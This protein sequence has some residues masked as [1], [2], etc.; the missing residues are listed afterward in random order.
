MSKSLQLYQKYRPTTL[1]D[2]VGHSNRVTQIKTWMKE[3][4]PQS[5]YIYGETGTGKTT[6]ARIIAS[7]INCTG[8]GETTPC[9][10][11]ESCLS[12]IQETFHLDI[13][14]INASNMNVDAARELDAASSIP[15]FFGGKK[16]WIIN[17]FQELWESPKAR[18]NLLEL[19]ENKNDNV[20]VI[21]TSMDDSKVDKAIRDRCKKI[22]LQGL[23]DEDILSKLIEVCGKEEVEVT[24]EVIEV[25]IL[26]TQNSGGS[27]RSAL[28]LLEEI[29]DMKL[30]KAED[31]AKELKLITSENLLTQIG[32]ILKGDASVLNSPPTKEALERMK[33]VL[34]GCVKANLGVEIQSYEK[35]NL[36][37]LPNLFSLNQFKFV[38]TQLTELYRRAYIDSFAIQNWLVDCILGSSNSVPSQHRP[39]D[40]KVEPEKTTSTPSAVV[41]GRGR[42]R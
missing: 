6:L 40:N 42:G 17:E 38:L 39:N 19:L 18:K 2:L 14:E 41:R 31:A 23:T 37:N 10:K 13:K 24:E 15:S 29:K 16:V 34:L 28:T 26:I 5:I 20:H 22:I 30:W 8:E 33:W 21:I 11:C 4:F 1:E 36:G 3:G 27:V 32:Q 7:S 12:V 25:L 9:G 35:K